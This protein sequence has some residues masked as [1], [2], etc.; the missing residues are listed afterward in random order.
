[1]CVGVLLIRVLVFTVFCILCIVF[2]VLFHLYIFILICFVCTSVRT[3]ATEDNSI[4]VSSSISSSSSRSD[5]T[6]FT[7]LSGVPILRQLNP[8]ITSKHLF[9]D[10]LQSNFPIIPS[11]LFLTLSLY[12]SVHTSSFTCMLHALIITQF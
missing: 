6:V 7:T 4:V 9:Q 10:K 11:S 12:S 3:T 8:M 5:I 2:F 1:V